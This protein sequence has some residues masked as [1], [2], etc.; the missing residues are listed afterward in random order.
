[1]NIANDLDGTEHYQGK[2]DQ[3]P[4]DDYYIVDEAGSAGFGVERVQAL[5]CVGR[6]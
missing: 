5:H 6:R 3:E 2:A 4:N 1:L